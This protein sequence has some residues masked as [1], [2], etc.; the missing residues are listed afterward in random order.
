MKKSPF[1]ALLFTAIAVSVV[2]T[3]PQQTAPASSLTVH[4]RPFSP[5]LQVGDTLYVS[6]HLGVLDAT[7]KPP[8]DPSGEARQVLLSVE[9]T[10]KDAGMTMDDLVYVEISCTDLNLYADFNKVYTSFFRK[11]F[12]AREFI[13]VKDLLF[14]AHFEVMGIAVRHAADNKKQPIPAAH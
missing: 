12:P 4:N 7:G 13:G 10:L 9:Q 1:L 3:E 6:G 2:P 11:P 14:G 5:G 8:A